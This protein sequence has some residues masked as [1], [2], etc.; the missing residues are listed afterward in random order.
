MVTPATAPKLSSLGPACSASLQAPLS[1]RTPVAILFHE[2]ISLDLVFELIKCLMTLGCFC[3]C[4][5]NKRKQ[6]DLE[7]K[8]YLFL[9]VE[10]KRKEKILAVFSLKE[11]SIENYLLVVLKIWQFHTVS[12]K[13][14]S[15]LVTFVKRLGK[16]WVVPVRVKSQE[17]RETKTPHGWLL[18]SHAL[19]LRSSLFKSHWLSLIQLQLPSVHCVTRTASQAWGPPGTAR[20]PLTGHLP[21]SCFKLLP[22]H[23]L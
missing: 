21:V 3:N 6:V 15:W 4:I 1:N 17:S 12:H 13:V 22:P 2:N 8:T 10:E 9:K 7:T 18:S 19:S 23:C 20:G 11:E 16:S 14:S 5:Y